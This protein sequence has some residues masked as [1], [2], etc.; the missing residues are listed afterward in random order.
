MNW[1]DFVILATLVAGFFWSFRHGFI[2]EVVYF[3]AALGGLLGAFLF[4]PFLEPLMGLVIENEQGAAGLA[5]AVLFVFLVGIIT[6]IGLL[7]HKFIHAIHLGAFDKLLGGVFGAVK[8]A[9]LVSVVLVMLV[10]IQ[11]E[12]QPAY[13]KESLIC[14]P[15]VGSAT[16]VFQTVPPIF[17][18]FHEDYGK[19]AMEWV[20]ATREK[21]NG[22]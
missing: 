3:V 20:E 2:M 9:V 21:V 16:S 11:G 7:L 6:I 8:A 18:T 15:L 12:E 1:L 19:R 10:G 22:E 17:R 4:Y 14:Q 13:V 5:F